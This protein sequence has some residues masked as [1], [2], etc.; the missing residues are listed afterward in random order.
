LARRPGLKKGYVYDVSLT[1]PR[2]ESLVL[3]ID[4]STIKIFL[5][6]S[7]SPLKLMFSSICVPVWDEVTFWDSEASQH[8][9][10]SRPQI[11]S[12]LAVHLPLIHRDAI[13]DSLWICAESRDYCAL[14]R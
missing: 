9:T 1:I 8:V 3:E 10:S 4:S 13:L 6:S 2:C 5:V 12:A 7:Y 14:L 11:S